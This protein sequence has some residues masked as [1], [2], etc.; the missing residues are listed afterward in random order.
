MT[1]VG[2]AH[3]GPVTCVRFSPDGTLLA[4]SSSD[5]KCKLWKVVKVFGK[6]SSEIT[7]LKLKYICSSKT[8]FTAGVNCI[9]FSNNGEF[10]AAGSDDATMVVWNLPSMDTIYASF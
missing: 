5:K 4:S 1:L 9:N 7:G 8:T 2:S 10:L 3:S 6:A